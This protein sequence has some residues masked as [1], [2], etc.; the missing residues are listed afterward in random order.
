[1]A[2]LKRVDFIQ[3]LVNTGLTCTQAQIAYKALVSFFED[4]VAA[5]DHICIGH[6]G[7][8]RPMRRKPRMITMGFKRD[9]SG[10]QRIK[11]N[12]LLGTRVAYTFKVYRAFG[13]QHGL[14]P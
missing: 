11:R 6:V 1:M 2:K 3:R 10:V 13:K 4:G 5:R 7:V 8:L 12:F 14:A 9:A